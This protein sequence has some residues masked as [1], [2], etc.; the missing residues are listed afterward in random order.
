MIC[1]TTAPKKPAH[2][3]GAESRTGLTAQVGQRPARLTFIVTESRS[4]MPIKLPLIAT[5]VLAT[6]AYDEWESQRTSEADRVALLFDM[7]LSAAV[8]RRHDCD[9]VEAP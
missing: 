8:V 6:A 4:A 2:P 7:L 3:R 1:R 9:R 5:S